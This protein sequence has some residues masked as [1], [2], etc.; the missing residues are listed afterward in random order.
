[1]KGTV[2][3]RKKNNVFGSKHVGSSILDGLHDFLG[4]KISFQLVSA[5]NA[6]P[7]LFFLP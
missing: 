4:K 6:A 3:L 5:E 2:V 1:M 7:G